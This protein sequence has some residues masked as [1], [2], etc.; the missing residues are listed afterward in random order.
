M[1]RPTTRKICA[2]EIKKSAPVIA[3]VTIKKIPDNFP[4]TCKEMI[5]KIYPAFVHMDR[6]GRIWYQI[7]L[8]DLGKFITKKEKT[9]SNIFASQ[10][11]ETEKV[12]FENRKF[13]VL[14]EKYCK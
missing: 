4:T 13:M 8:N 12:S 6:K 11:V 10:K 5:G 1:P 3:E 9:F 14:E 2:K 7:L